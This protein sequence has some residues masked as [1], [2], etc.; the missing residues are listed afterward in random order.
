M[1]DTIET[2]AK[3]PLI[4]VITLSYNSEY[5]LDSIQSVL[6]QTYP[7][8][9]YII[10][11]DGSKSFD[12]ELIDQYIQKHR[13]ANICD[14]SITVNLRN[15]G[16]VKAFNIALR[17]ARGEYI[18]NLAA[19]DLFYATD[20][21]AAWVAEFIKRD[22]LFMMGKMAVCTSDMAKVVDMRPYPEEEKLFRNSSSEELFEAMTGRNL[23]I[24]CCTARSQKCLKEYGFFDEDF[25]L[26]EDYP[27]AMRLLRK[28]GRI[29]YWEQVV[30]KYRPGGVSAPQNYNSTYEYD[31]DLNFRKEI[32]PYTKHKIRAY[33]RYHY[34]KWTHKESGRF[35]VRYRSIR[36]SKRWYLLPVLCLRFPFISVR[37]LWGRRKRKRTEKYNL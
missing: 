5:L 6:E 22:A 2:D 12:K 20:I 37:A 29:D 16:I 17:E 28:G 21:L 31:S 3:N 23:V 13:G 36:S 24:G 8:I 11:D 32:F 34:W 7:S 26:L 35:S 19:D 15:L 10:V 14:Y 30:V 1:V 33:L 25:F 9:Q 18:F 4:T 27:Y